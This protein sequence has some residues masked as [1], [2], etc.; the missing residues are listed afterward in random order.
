MAVGAMVGNPIS[1]GAI[2]ICFVGVA[3]ST[4]SKEGILVGAIVNLAAGAAVVVTIV[5]T[6][7]VPGLIIVGA[8]VI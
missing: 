7:V 6:S 4:L 5:G 2:V 8:D 1:V 3:V